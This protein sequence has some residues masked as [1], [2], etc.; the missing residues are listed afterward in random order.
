MAYIYE[1]VDNSDEEQYFSLG[2]F[3]DKKEAVNEF[4]S[5]REPADFGSPIMPEEQAEFEVREH[6][7]GWGS[8]Y[9]VVASVKFISKYNEKEDDYKWEK[10]INSIED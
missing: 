7:V 8:Y 10:S 4:N 2:Y 5:C 1:I 3:I 6:K 9:K